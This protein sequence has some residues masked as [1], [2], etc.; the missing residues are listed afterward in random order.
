MKN[1]NARYT[2]MPNILQ[3]R[4]LNNACKNVGLKLK[5]WENYI[6]KNIIYVKFIL[7]FIYL[8]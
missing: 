5:M 4:K 7:I 2:C 6:F 8:F 1:L 3:K